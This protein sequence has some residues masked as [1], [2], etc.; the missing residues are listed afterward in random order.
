M[1]LSQ[2][3]ADTLK[4]F[5][6]RFVSY[7]GMHYM[8]CDQPQE[9]ENCIGGHLQSRNVAFFHLMASCMNLKSNGD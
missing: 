6:N 4:L 2:K 9:Y 8:M 3:T 5:M 1:S 7:N